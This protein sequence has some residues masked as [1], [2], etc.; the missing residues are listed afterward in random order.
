MGALE[1]RKL[2]QEQQ[3]CAGGAVGQRHVGGCPGQG[4]ELRGLQEDGCCYLVV[5]QYRLRTPI[6][7]LCISY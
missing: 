2:Q 7:E 5:V 6:L 4:L 3:D 1:E